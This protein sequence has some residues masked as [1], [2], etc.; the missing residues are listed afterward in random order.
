MSISISLQVGSASVQEILYAA[1]VN[2][3]STRCT[4]VAAYLASIRDVAIDLIEYL[5]AGGY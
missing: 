4:V 2:P 5:R 3:A 1:T